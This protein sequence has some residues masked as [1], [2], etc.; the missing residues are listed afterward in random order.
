MICK[1]ILLF[2]KAKTSVMTMIF[3]D[4]I[5]GIISFDHIS[6]QGIINFRVQQCRFLSLVSCEVWF[7]TKSKKLK[8]RSL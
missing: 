5:L 8:K 3:Q 4:S 2:S 6:S 1:G 7:W